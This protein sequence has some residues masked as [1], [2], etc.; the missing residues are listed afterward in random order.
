MNLSNF[1][2]A[3]TEH[4]RG[5]SFTR[6]FYAMV[7]VRGVTVRGFRMGGRGELL[8][9]PESAVARRIASQLTLSTF[10]PVST[11]FTVLP[12]VRTTTVQF[13]PF[14]LAL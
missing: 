6:A 8:R 10:I 11:A 3:P 12:L 9:N 4:G 14:A 13:L 1:W 7:G 2:V 5:R